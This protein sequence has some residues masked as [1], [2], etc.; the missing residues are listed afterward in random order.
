MGV[1]ARLAVLVGIVEGTGRVSVA[2]GRLTEATVA[3]AAG[4]IAPGRQALTAARNK[5]RK[6]AQKQALFI[7]PV[8][9]NKMEHRWQPNR[10]FGARMRFQVAL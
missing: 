4:G 5:V 8:R 10:R 9:S 1:A 6:N 2:T 3:S 7:S